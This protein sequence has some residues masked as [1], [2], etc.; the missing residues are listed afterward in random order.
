MDRNGQRHLQG[1][2][3]SSFFLFPEVFPELGQATSTTLVW[4]HHPIPF[5]AR[6]EGT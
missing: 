6:R 1:A 5:A 2:A 4:L 3:M